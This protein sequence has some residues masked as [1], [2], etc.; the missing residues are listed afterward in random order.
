MSRSTHNR[1]KLRV[2]PISWAVLV[3][4]SVGLSIALSWGGTTSAT[5]HTETK[6]VQS[7]AGGASGSGWNSSNVWVGSA[8]K[9]KWIRMDNYFNY[10]SR[11]WRASN[12]CTSG[13][14]SNYKTLPWVGATNIGAVQGK[15]GFWT[16]GDDFTE[17]GNCGDR[18]ADGG[19]GSQL[20][21]SPG[22]VGGWAH[23]GW[24]GNNGTA[25]S[26]EGASGLDSGHLTCCSPRVWGR[27][28]KLTGAANEH[29]VK[30]F[31][32]NGYSGYSNHTDSSG[33]PIGLRS[34][35][36][37]LF[38]QEFELTQDEY[39]RLFLS[40][41]SAN[42]SMRADD[43]FILYINGN[44]ITQETLS[45]SAFSAN[46]KSALNP[47]TN[48][49]AA[50]V[51]D[52]AR[53][54]EDPN[55]SNAAGLWYEL[56]M[57]MPSLP[58]PEGNVRVYRT[59]EGTTTGTPS[60]NGG[61]VNLSGESQSSSN[62]HQWS[63]LDPGGRT[64]TAK[65]SYSSGNATYRRTGFRD[66]GLS[67]CNSS[68]H[69]WPSTSS[70]SLGINV[71]SDETRHARAY[72]TIDRPPNINFNANCTT[73]SGTVSDPDHSGPFSGT[74]RV[75]RSSGD[76]DDISFTT[77]SSGNF[78][79]DYPEGRQTNQ[80]HTVRV[81]AQGRRSDGSSSGAKTRTTGWQTVSECF[82]ASCNSTSH[83]P[84]AVLAGTD[85]STTATFRNRG[86]LSWNQ[87]GR[88]TTKGKHGGVTRTPTV[89]STAPGNNRTITYGAGGFTAPNT[90][91]EQTV[92]MELFADGTKLAECSESFDPYTEYELSAQITNTSL[93]PSQENPDT[94]RLKSRVDVD[95]SPVNGP[96]IQGPVAERKAK[97]GAGSSA[98]A[99]ISPSS[100]SNNPN[101][102]RAFT[103]N[104]SVSGHQAGDRYCGKIVVGPVYGWINQ[105]GDRINIGGGSS[106]DGWD[107]ETVWDQPYV[108]VFGGDAITAG[109][110]GTG[111]CAGGGVFKT[112]FD[113]DNN[114]GS[115]SQ[116]AAIAINNIY[117][118]A[119]A[120]M[121]TSD[122]MPR[123]G[124][125]FANTGGGSASSPHGG[126]YPGTHCI[127]DYMSNAP[128]GMTGT[129]FNQNKANSL[130]S[131]SYELNSNSIS[132][133][134][135]TSIPDGKKFTIYRHQGDVRIHNNIIYASDSW[136]SL[137]NISSFYLI[138][139]GNIYIH[140]RVSRLD[141]IYIAQPDNNG[142]GGIIYTCATGTTPKIPSEMFNQCD[143]PL[144]VNGALISR[145]AR[146]NR[147]GG[148]SLRYGNQAEHP[149]RSNR[150][151][152]DE[153]AGG[154][155]A[156]PVCAAET[157]MFGPDIY[158][159][160]PA[161]P[162]VN[163]PGQGAYDAITS[164][165]PAF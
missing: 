108:S 47:G 106:V 79:V 39:D 48:V 153:S 9:S 65:F 152:A 87:G 120:K 50:Q 107:C 49:I 89:P 34:N 114:R 134:S 71:V 17:S 115:G 91:D 142:D 56:S 122:P 109:S 10:Q 95:Y 112:Y 129:A 100:F 24:S 26:T 54:H 156:R 131:G 94:F 2:I 151:C 155:Q 6:K 72:Y 158:L 137:G 154:Y 140:R 15:T 73:I 60:G 138:V 61:W 136:S 8:H 119:S 123:K 126:N 5:S 18:Y 149:L 147:Y 85:F 98:T 16:T 25:K 80:T 45:P 145:V 110:F 133:G 128:S 63:N 162:T 165:T 157:I 75:R 99:T 124:L 113:G 83:S 51:V 31:Q 66:C 46:V 88:V 160:Q 14:T 36:V 74:V 81:T 116:F 82:L 111:S 68:S 19:A 148:S 35:G 43:F 135:G 163:A 22:S 21:L 55:V 77:N 28:T 62:P 127:T 101:Y 130:S 53:W 102:P 38:N 3:L 59:I 121:R 132:G 42:I 141:G 146:L 27:S 90:L 37:T 12:G 44:Y 4:L 143:K 118:F 159:N 78:N 86:Q 29:A 11:L 40:G 70:S 67:A 64:F 13:S 117:R 69:R 105:D 20:W 57:D 93:R 97:V 150:Q 52:K 30:L 1:Y 84:S 7:R 58:P 76:Y 96:D 33:N 161:L 92:T 104:F 23:S 144:D 41:G 125:T 103:D 32:D 164:L 139:E